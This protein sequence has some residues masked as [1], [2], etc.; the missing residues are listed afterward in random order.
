M[1]LKIKNYKISNKMME[2]EIIFSFN[3]IKYT[4]KYPSN[5]NLDNQ[6]FSFND[7]NI[8][9]ALV[10]LVEIIQDDEYC[11]MTRIQLVNFKQ[12]LIKIMSLL[13]QIDL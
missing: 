9:K 1:L 7:L 13:N 6:M 5:P 4:L 12:W 2:S 11:I 10:T 3:T 8:E